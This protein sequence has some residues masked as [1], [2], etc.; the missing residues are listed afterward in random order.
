MDE[1]N[2]DGGGLGG[3]KQA[4]PDNG[5][6]ATMS[7]VDPTGGEKRVGDDDKITMMNKKEGGGGND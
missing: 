7:D 2:V 6:D 4:T 5:G 1:G 3:K